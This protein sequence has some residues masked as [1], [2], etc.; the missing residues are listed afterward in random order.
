MRILD[1]LDLKILKK[2]EYV[3]FA[4][5]VDIP[6]ELIHATDDT[7]ICIPIIGDKIGIRYEFCPPYMVKDQV[8]NYYTLIT[9]GINSD[10]KSIEGLKREV[11]EEAG[12]IIKDYDIL[13][14]KLNIPIW[15][16]TDNRMYFYIIRINDYEKIIPPGDG[17]KNEQK[18]VTKWITLDEYKKLLNLDN[19][20]Y[21]FSIS[22]YLLKG[23]I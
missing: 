16:S 8:R 1:D 7:I 6:Y 21:L 14:Q 15:K 18:S 9:G 19:V 2:G 12:V 13:F 20:D 17:T 22:Y 3:D 4:T 23:V 11:K 5:P 10:E